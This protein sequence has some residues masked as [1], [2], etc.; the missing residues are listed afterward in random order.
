MTPKAQATQGK[1]DKWKNIKL[2]MLMTVT[3]KDTIN[4]VKRPSVSNSELPPPTY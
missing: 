3:S 4:R 1:I 2:T